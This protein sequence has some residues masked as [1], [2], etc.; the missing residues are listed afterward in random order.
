MQTIP[1]ATLL[2][3]NNTLI[4]NFDTICQ[5]L[6]LNLYKGMKCY[7]GNCPIHRGDNHT[8]LAIYHT[9][10]KCAGNWHCHTFGC[11][12]FFTP[13]MIGFIRGL[14][15]QRHYKWVD[16]GKKESFQNTVEFI[17]RVLDNE[18]IEVADDIIKEERLIE[19][20]YPI[21]LLDNL[22]IPSPY[23][24]RRGFKASTIERLN[25]GDCNI[26]GKSFNKRAVIPIFDAKGKYI[27]GFTA[28]S[29][30]DAC[31][32]C[33]ANHNPAFRCPEKAYRHIFCK[34]KNSSFH[35]MNYLYNLHN[36]VWQK[37]NNT[38]IVVEGPPNVMRF[39][40]AGIFNVVATLGK[41]M[42]PKHVELLRENNYNTVLMAYDNDEEGRKATQKVFKANKDFLMKPLQ[43]PTND[44]ACMSVEQ[45]NKILLPQIKEL[46]C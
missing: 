10:Y 9:G 6:K 29:L 25:I 35:K 17:N 32:Q 30:Y 41:E 4:N 22:T 23:F 27:V 5:K 1:Q 11:H 20:N 16:T 36:S 37:K 34:W 44:I 33:G 7:H 8:A 24:I 12:T 15:S 43:F 38:I 13:N 2:K 21:S 26:S 39:Y 46:S 42:S 28:R 19:R 45:I 40:D 31:P 18:E 14:L 3:L